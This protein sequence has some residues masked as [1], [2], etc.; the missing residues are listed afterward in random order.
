MYD[1]KNIR[2]THEALTNI[3]SLVN[4]AKT[5]GLVDVKA[6]V[7]E[8][9]ENLSFE[10]TYKSNESSELVSRLINIPLRDDDEY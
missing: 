6:G 10:L 2:I 7:D 4:R 5:E 1:I 9:F 8:N 3:V